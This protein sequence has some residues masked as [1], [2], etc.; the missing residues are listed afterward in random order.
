MTENNQQQFEDIVC[1]PTLMQYDDEQNLNFERALQYHL[2]KV[3]E[4]RT[5]FNQYEA[6]FRFR[7]FRGLI[8]YKKKT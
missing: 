7:V 8:K 4:I 5:V 2:A 6:T 1:S 3:R